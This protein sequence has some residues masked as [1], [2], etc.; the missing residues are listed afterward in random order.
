MPKSLA[1]TDVWVSGG[2]KKVYK[3]Q[4]L[5]YSQRSFVREGLRILPPATTPWVTFSSNF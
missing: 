3:S 2:R 4:N 1:I 5:L